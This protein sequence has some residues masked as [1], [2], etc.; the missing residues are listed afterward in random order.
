M[1]TKYH[2]R[3]RIVGYDPDTEELVFSKEI[4][5]KVLD[6]FSNVIQ[7]QPDDPDGYDSYNVTWLAMK[8]LPMLGVEL[9]P[10]RLDYFIE[11]QDVDPHRKRAG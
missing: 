6:L 11:P 3:H 2:I 10:K 8:L 9:H 4:P 5:D 1:T 7:F